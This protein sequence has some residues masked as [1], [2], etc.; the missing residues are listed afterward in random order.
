MT[1]DRRSR[2]A[3]IV[4]EAGQRLRRYIRARVRSDADAEDVLQDVW[5]RL[6]TALDSGPVEQVGAWLYTVARNRII[7]RARKPATASLEALTDEQDETAFEFPGFLLRD[8]H[9]P[10]TEHRRQLFWDALHAAL[11]ELPQEQRQVF[12]WHEF[13]ALSFQDM[14][15]LTG[16]NVNTLLGRKRYAVLHLRRRLAPLREEFFP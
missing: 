3:A 4:S 7:D 12:V 15:A 14:A 10:V 5:E 16:E 8:D 11:A 9:T 6:V 13:E 1:T 2:V